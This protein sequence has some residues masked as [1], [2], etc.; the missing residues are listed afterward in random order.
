M[1]RIIYT[2]SL[3]LSLNFTLLAQT[4][5]AMNGN[6]FIPDQT[7]E[8]NYFSVSKT[9][10]LGVRLINKSKEILNG[11]YYVVDGNSAKFSFKIPSDLETGIYHLIFYNESGY[12]IQTI[13]I[14]R[15]EE[16]FLNSGSDQITKG[17]FDLS[18]QQIQ[19]R[20]S[21]RMQV[22]LP[23][24]AIAAFVHAL[25]KNH[26]MQYGK[27]VK[28]DFEYSG[29]MLTVNDGNGK[30]NLALN[31]FNDNDKLSAIYFAEVLN[32]KAKIGSEMISQPGEVRLSADMEVNSL[33]WTDDI[34]IVIDDVP[35]P[36]FRTSMSGEE[37]DLYIKD[38]SARKKINNDF[39]TSTPNY[40]D[41]TQQ[42]SYPID[43]TIS[44]DDY[45]PFKT[46]EDVIK[47]VLPWVKVKGKSDPEILLMTNSYNKKIDR[48]PMTLYNYKTLCIVDDVV[49]F[50]DSQILD[51]DPSLINKIDVYLNKIIIGGRFFNGVLRL[52]SKKS[53][54]LLSQLSVEINPPKVN[55]LVQN[56]TNEVNFRSPVFSSVENI[57]NGVLRKSF[58]H[59]DERGEFKVL[60]LS[61]TEKGDLKEFASSYYVR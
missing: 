21:L 30:G 13:S 32:G 8:L 5:V 33:K 31:C 45:Y 1:L 26:E 56:G 22:L 58:K 20:D 61:I 41:T 57:N 53:S 43:Y 39:S 40:N 14:G 3:L 9:T 15:P 54:N 29:L 11:N 47:E 36:K 34:S 49:V 25:P 23:S 52:T 42:L 12:N 59:S 24:D 17:K 28:Y 2:F 19:T 18:E 37:I 6:I 46:M 35:L 44:L 60:I 27:F 16:D 48:T 10:F 4:Y 55:R 51:L 38:I 7:V 50:N